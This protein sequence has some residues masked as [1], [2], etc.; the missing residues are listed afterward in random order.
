MHSNQTL[1]Q[2]TPTT[3]GTPTCN[4]YRPCQ[5]AP[6]PGVHQ[7]NHTYVN[8]KNTA[9]KNPNQTLHPTPVL[10]A[11]RNIRVIFPRIRTRVLSNE[12]SRSVMCVVSR[13]S[14]PIATVIYSSQPGTTWE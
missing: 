5:H 3:P 12:F 13:I 7:L 1:K 14:S 11:I 10:S 4:L 9:T 2:A 6:F 8:S